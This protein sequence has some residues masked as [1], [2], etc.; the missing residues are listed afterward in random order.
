[1]LVAAFAHLLAVLIG[2][3]AE[4][5]RLDRQF[6]A[7]TTRTRRVNSLATIGRLVMQAPDVRAVVLEEISWRRL[8]LRLQ[9]QML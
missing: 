2:L 4:K 9:A 1:M 6:Q 8:R 7:N 3:A 5:L